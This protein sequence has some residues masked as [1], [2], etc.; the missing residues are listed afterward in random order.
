MD[1]SGFHVECWDVIIWAGF[2]FAGFRFEFAN[3]SGFI[4]HLNDTKVIF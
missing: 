3:I 1:V 4:A 2:V